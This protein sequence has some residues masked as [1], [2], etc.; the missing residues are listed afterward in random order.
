MYF[1]VLAIER[2]VLGCC[3]YRVCN[4]GVFFGL[5]VAIS[6]GEMSGWKLEML[7]YGFAGGGKFV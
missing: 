5:R 6:R 4:A 2:W 1:H 3:G 7:F